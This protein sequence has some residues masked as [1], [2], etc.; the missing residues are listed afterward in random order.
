MWL[1]VNVMNCTCFSDVELNCLAQSFSP[2][3]FFELSC[4]PSIEG[5]NI[6]FATCSIDGAPPTQCEL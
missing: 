2:G 3:P 4:I 5:T 6:T 1:F